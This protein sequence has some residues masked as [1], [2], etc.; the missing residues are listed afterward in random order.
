[1][2]DVEV[3]VQTWPSFASWSE[4]RRAAASLPLKTT[5]WRMAPEKWVMSGV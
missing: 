3:E 4:M 2:Q 5:A 1:M